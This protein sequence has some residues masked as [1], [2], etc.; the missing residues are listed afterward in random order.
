MD[1]ALATISEAL[2]GRADD[3]LSGVGDRA[4]ARTGIAEELTLEYP[5]LEPAARAAIIDRVME[6]LVEEDFFGIE[7]VG[8]PFS[9]PADM[10]DE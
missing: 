10:V 3:F 6:I 1:E 2:A 8:D 9:D 5:G 7:F 4:G